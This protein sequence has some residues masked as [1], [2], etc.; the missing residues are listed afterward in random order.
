MTKVKTILAFSQP[1]T[2]VILEDMNERELEQAA[3]EAYDQNHLARCI[4]I[5]D[6]ILSKQQEISR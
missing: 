5:I 1:L 4:R 2:G 3:R 6:K